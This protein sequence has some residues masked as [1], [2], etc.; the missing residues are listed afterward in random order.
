M[1]AIHTPHSQP[2]A[3]TRGNVSPKEIRCPT[4]AANQQQ[5]QQQGH[6]GQVVETA[7][8]T[9]TPTAPPRTHS[10]IPPCNLTGF[11]GVRK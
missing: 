1:S 6:G 2:R 8:G 4:A 10:P 11:Q 5:Q 9:I 3:S 7:N